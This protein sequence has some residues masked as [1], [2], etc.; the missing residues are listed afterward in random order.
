MNQ[1][2]NNQLKSVVLSNDKNGYKTGVFQQNALLKALNETADLD[3]LKKVA[4]F[5][6]KAE[7]LKTLDKIAIR[8]EYHEALAK[9]DLGLDDIVSGMSTLARSSNEKIKLGALTTL[10]KTLGLDKYEVSENQGKNWEELLLQINE[11]EKTE[12]RLIGESVN[13]L[14]T[15][16]VVYDVVV[17]KMPS[18]AKQQREEDKVT[19]SSI[20]E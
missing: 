13:T 17:P 16:D 10:L 20:Y 14:K 3:E 6:S 5:N 18:S 11:A 19:E 4:N 12:S 15:N 8:R 9:H 1:E 7:V 2:E